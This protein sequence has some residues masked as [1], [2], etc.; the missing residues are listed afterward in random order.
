[1]EQEGRSR[2]EQGKPGQIDQNDLELGKQD[3]VPE[4]FKDK[5]GR[6]RIL[7]AHV[8]HGGI[9]DN[10]KSEGKQGKQARQEELVASTL[11]KPSC[12]LINHRK[13][14]KKAIPPQ[15]RTI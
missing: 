9:A 15:P 10:G 7:V 5:G 4:I 1:V 14:L 3:R 8:G 12:R 6:L 11:R 2:A 13:R